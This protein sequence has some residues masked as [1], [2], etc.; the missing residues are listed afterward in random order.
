MQQSWFFSSP[1]GLPKIGSAAQAEIGM[2]S[3]RERI[4]DLADSGLA[5]SELADALARFGESA[6]GGALL[7][8]VFANSRFLTQCIVM[9]IGF[10]SGLL[11][12]GPEKVVSQVI[13]RLKHD[14]SDQ[15]ERA[16]LMA[17]LRVARRRMAL[18]V[19]LA[20]LTGRWDVARVT[21]ALSG[22]ADA[23]L[24][25]ALSHLLRAAAARGDLVLRQ[26]DRPEQD[27]GYVVLALG[28]YGAR[29]L[30]YS[31]DIDLIVLY[32]LDRFDYRGPRSPQEAL[33]L[34]TRNLVSILEERTGDGY[35]FRT[36]LR[37]RPDPAAMPIALSIT[38]ALSYYESMGQN[39]E[40]AAMIKARAAA[41]D[42]AAGAAFL[43]E[44]SPFVWRKNLDFWAIQDIHSI[45]RQINAHKGGSEIAVLGQNIKLGR[46]GI[47]EIEF[48]AQTQQLIYAGR[49]PGLRSPRTVAALACLADSGHIDQAAA[50]ELSEAYNFLRRLEHR[51]QM[52]DDQQTHS[53]PQD[54]AGLARIAAFM[55]YDGP[56]SFTAALL[57]RLRRVESAYAELFEETPSLSD[58]GNLVFTGGEPDPETVKTLQ[59]L[60]YRD[61]AGVFNLVRGWHHGRYRATRSTRARELLTEL[62]P[63]LLE[64][65]GKTPGPDAALARF[66]GF[67]GGL[68]AG[69]QLFSLLHA[70][71]VLLDLLAEIMGSA[72]AMAEHLSRN[73]G[74]LDVV[75]T[76]G[77]FAAT[78]PN[79]ALTRE[80]E[81]A[82][83][84]ARDVQDLL[85][86]SRRWAND[87]RFQVSAHILR[88]ESD[89]DEAGHA[90]SD[91]AE[92]VIAALA[93]PVQ[94]DL[95]RSHGRV[96]GSGL[97]VLALGKLGSREM[98]I[99]SDLDLIFLYDGPE[100]VGDLDG[101][102]PLPASQYYARLAQRIIN[103]ISA[104]TAEGRLYEIDMRLRPSGKSGPIA[105]TLVGFRQ[106]QETS[107]WTWEHMALTRARV[108]AGEP[109]LAA[110]IDQSVR[111][112]LT[113]P[114]DP[115][116][117]LADV[118]EMRARLEREFPARDLWN[119]KYL[120][121]GLMDLDFIAQYLQLRHGAAHPE[122]LQGTTAGAFAH[123]AQAGLLGASLAQRLIEA[124]RLM[125][126]VQAFLRLTVGGAFD[127]AAA[128]EGLKGS[129]ARAAGADSFADLKGRLITT[130][131][132]AYEAY[133]ELIDV[134]AKAATVETAPPI[135][136]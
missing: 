67:L 88:H 74:L 39:W 78:P 55:G 38:A 54:Q 25:A 5:D 56:E 45:K 83:A 101:P 2:G 19:G 68:P 60:G 52:V 103:A 13:E 18:A 127:E 109:G 69:V 20:D 17:G 119:V 108:V 104:L 76:R 42:L 96:P 11:S 124:A 136:G 110:R 35:V 53:L 7:R 84:A 27:C 32:D 14:L 58:P 15:P 24:S 114:R 47:R 82:L 46:G 30:N 79:P 107:A 125:R 113:A 122:I 66:D 43:A 75:L 90:L 135:K 62:M 95:A 97:A 92:A 64:A 63:A 102:K 16:C 87:R 126:Q 3:W 111:A 71:P 73:A 120:R 61:G 33:V 94:D 26:P 10:F 4:A 8:A 80:L 44:L 89:V 105:T 72:P 121:G 133:V 22:F 28:K 50:L 81:A 65:L 132:T 98:T 116:K 41:G 134:P 131:Q 34:M 29:E 40:R 93:G 106:Y 130:A 70:N 77:F 31:S 21:E 59:T 91:I 48:F 1:S 9:D 37:L 85:D 123:L 128:T 112:I 118:A 117:L 57:R 51:L 100:G 36:D 86:L 115:G 129:L 99:S 49:E 6:D 23:V 12:E